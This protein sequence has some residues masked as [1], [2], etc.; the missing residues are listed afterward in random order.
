MRKLV[1]TFIIGST[2]GVG[3]CGFLYSFHQFMD[4]D[5][6]APQNILI[7]AACAGVFSVG[8]RSAFL[9]IPWRVRP[10]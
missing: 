2:I 5:S 9:S 7:C 8:Q 6:D 3:V 10:K 4:H 1:A